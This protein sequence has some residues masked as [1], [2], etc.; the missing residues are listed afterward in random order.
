MWSECDNICD[1][2]LLN[3]SGAFAQYFS[4]QFYKINKKR[5]QRIEV[6]GICLLYADE[7]AGKTWRGGAGRTSTSYKE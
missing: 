4:K 5:G 6:W 7:N 2:K 1:V 3:N